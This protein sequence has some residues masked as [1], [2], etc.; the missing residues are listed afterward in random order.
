M[1]Q[2][3]REMVVGDKT[4]PYGINHAVS[5]GE[6]EQALVPGHNRAA[7]YEAGVECLNNKPEGLNLRGSTSGEG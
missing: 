6:S 1:E 7:R 2:S 3:R 5:R 4:R